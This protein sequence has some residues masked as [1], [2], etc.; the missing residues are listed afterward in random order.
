MSNDFLAFEETKWLSLA[1]CND[2]LASARLGKTSQ[3]NQ[4]WKSNTPI[5]FPTSVPFFTNG[6][7]I[8]RICTTYVTPIGCGINKRINVESHIRFSHTGYQYIY[9]YLKTINM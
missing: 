8:V 3:R 1:I 7:W 5:S 9:M 2:L 6:Y 4:T